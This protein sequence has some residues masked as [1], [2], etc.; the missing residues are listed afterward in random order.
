M[1]R[2]AVYIPPVD[3]S[4]LDV[5]SETE[6]AKTEGSSKSPLAQRGF[7]HNPASA[8]HGG[9]IAT[10]GI[11]R[12]ATRSLAALH[13]LTAGDDKGPLALR[14]YVFGLALAALTANTSSYLR[15]GCNLVIDSD[16]PREFHKV[17]RDGRRE[18]ATI[19]HPEA[20][21][22]ASAAAETFGKGDSRT[23]AF[24]QQKAKADVKKKD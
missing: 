7:V 11:R 13:L 5:F 8:S 14:R 12:D 23:V 6:K 17:Y 16:N 21:E 15:Q 2:G 1:T 4:D 18:P 9:V 19:S 10:G 3:Y 22:F 24:D 20:I